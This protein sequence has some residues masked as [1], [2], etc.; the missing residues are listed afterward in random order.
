MMLAT[1]EHVIEELAG[2]ERRPADALIRHARDKL[3]SEMSA[4]SE[5]TSALITKTRD[6]RVFS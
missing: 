1:Y 5:P 4:R 3:A 6:M 2:T